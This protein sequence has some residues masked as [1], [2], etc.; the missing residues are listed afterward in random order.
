MLYDLPERIFLYNIAGMRL[1]QNDHMLL[2]IRKLP[3]RSARFSF[4]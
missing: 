2:C 3:S 4:L 1:V